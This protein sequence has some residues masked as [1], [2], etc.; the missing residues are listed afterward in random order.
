MMVSSQEDKENLSEI[1]K[2]SI[3]VKDGNNWLYMANL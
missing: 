1:S 3:C 2:K